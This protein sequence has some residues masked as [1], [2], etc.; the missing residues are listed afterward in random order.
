MVV[1]ASEGGTVNDSGETQNENTNV[2]LTA[3]QAEGY[4]FSGWSGDATGSTNPLS[5]NIKS[6]KNTI[7][8]FVRLQYSLGVNIIESGTVSQVLVE[9]TEK[10]I[11]YDSFSKF[12]L[13]A[14]PE[15][16]SIFYGWTGSPT[17]TTSEIDVV[18]EGTKSVTATFEERLSQVIGVDDVFF[19]NGKWKIRKPKGISG[20][21][22]E[23]GEAN[24]QALAN[25][26]LSEIIF[27]TDGSFTI[28]S[29][30]T[31]PTGQF[32]VD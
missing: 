13:T 12:R 24:K 15:I 26:E 22:Q 16:N 29:G 9:S 27:R 1:S 14:Q 20:P 23:D 25:C 2:S 18:M 4:S 32:I 30:T 8:S 17:E 11:D 21:D 19:G 28:V 6:D 31:T 5:V 7:A 3:T 10:N